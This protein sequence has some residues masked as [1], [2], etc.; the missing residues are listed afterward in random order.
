M[1][2]KLAAPK[3][4]AIRFDDDRHDVYIYGNAVYLSPKEWHIL[5][6]L[7]D[8]KKIQTRE[9]LIAAVWPERAGLD[10][11]FRTVDQHVAR[12]RT[13]VGRS[14]VETVPEF[15]YRIAAGV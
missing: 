13:K 15:G 5:R 11:D 7:H 14:L 10:L 6:L 8:T 4:P 1:K 3:E 12:L 2:K 9:Q